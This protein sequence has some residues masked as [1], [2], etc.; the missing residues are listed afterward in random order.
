MKLIINI[1]L[2]GLKD[3]IC[4]LANQPQNYSA[5]KQHP[6][7]AFI[8]RGGGGKPKNV[9][10]QN[11]QKQKPKTNKTELWG[12]EN[13][14]RRRGTPRA[15]AA[16][17][18]S[19]IPPGFRARARG[20]LGNAPDVRIFSRNNLPGRGVKAG[21]SGLPGRGPTPPGRCPPGHPPR[22]H[23]LLHSGSAQRLRSA[24]RRPRSVPAAAAQRKEG[25]G[26]R[27]SSRARSSRGSGGGGAAAM[28]A[29]AGGGEGADTSAAAAG[30]R[31]GGGGTGRGGRGRRRRKAAPGP[32]LP[33]VSPSRRGRTP[34]RGPGSF[35]LS[36]RAERG[37]LPLFRAYQR[38]V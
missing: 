19:P 7:S 9:T 24:K 21:G 33:A 6:E 13:L 3:D 35:S 28:L 5:H 11:A 32:S 25:G 34:R 22:P 15:G 12:R 27:S 8:T 23:S 4:V 36:L 20:A 2:D 14:A 31:C 29:G 30:G 17:S 16:F 37:L 10:K 38:P 1:K 26:G 18:F